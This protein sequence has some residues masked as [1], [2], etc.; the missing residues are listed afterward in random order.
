MHG[1]ERHLEESPPGIFADVE[2]K[3]LVFN[4]DSKV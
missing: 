1:T 4:L 3:R 2:K